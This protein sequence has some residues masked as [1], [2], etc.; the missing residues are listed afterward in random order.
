MAIVAKKRRGG[1]AAQ[2]RG[3]SP[4]APQSAWLRG[5]APG[6]RALPWAGAAVLVALAALL[7]WRWTAR[8]P[9]SSH[10]AGEQPAP[11][12][13]R[14][15]AR[16][17]SSPHP[18]PTPAAES[19]AASQESSPHPAE[20]PAPPAEPAVQLVPGRITLPNGKTLSFKPPEEGTTTKVY[21]SGHTYEAFPDGSF[22]DI[23]PRK[24]FGTA[25][26]NQFQN[27]LVDG[28]MA[29]AT[30]LTG[31]DEEKVIELLRKPVVFEDID[32]NE[33]RETKEAM[34]E[35][36]AAALDYIE[37]GGTFDEFVTEAQ[38]FA[39]QERQLKAKGLRSVMERYKE[40]DYAGARER[41]DAVNGALA[42]QG[43]L[44]IRL[45]AH[46]K[47]ALGVE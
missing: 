31:L 9:E 47:A 32:T 7:A 8:R 18:A 22:K 43:F 4:S 19:A 28:N 29:I 33:E 30:F 21:A 6:M 34:A 40:G 39:N 16:S 37:A 46:V 11:P 23:T 45:P 14:A 20:A 26:E 41:L 3:R 13:E 36:K 2:G 35:M 17:E 25:F 27:A 5:G 38:T 42:T 24:L 44:E 15:A 1:K 12:V 10:P